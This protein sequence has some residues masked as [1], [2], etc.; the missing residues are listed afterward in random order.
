MGRQRLKYTEPPIHLTH[1]VRVIRG[2]LNTGSN[3]KRICIQWT[4]LLNGFQRRSRV[5]P[6]NRDFIVL[7]L[8]KWSSR[9]CTYSSIVPFHG[10]GSSAL[11]STLES[12]DF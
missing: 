2:P 1:C 12:Q 10:S 6:S 11:L 9:E 7:S 8:K 4:P 3:V 5:C